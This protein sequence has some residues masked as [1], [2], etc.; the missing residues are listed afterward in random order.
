MN[1]KTVLF[2]VI[3]AL[4]VAIVVLI[5]VV[6]GGG[7]GS[8]SSGGTSASDTG[9][10]GGDTAASN[11][12]LR[13][14][15]ADP[16]TLDP[17]L[18][19]D[20]DSATYIVEIFSGLVTI[21]KDLKIAPDLAESWDIS[22]DGTVYTFHLRSNAQFQDG[23]P[24]S[25]DDVKYSLERTANPKTTS[26]VADAYLGD[27]VGARDMIRGRAQSI[28]GIKVI[29]SKTV[30]ITVDGPKPYFL[31]KLTYTAA[32]VVDKNQVESNP[33]NWTRK[34]N[35]TGPYKLQE[36]RLNERIILQANDHYHLGAPSVK[37]VLYNLAGGSSLTQYQNG[38]VDISGIS[39]N[40][41]DRVLNKSD[42]LSKE[43][44]TAPSL[45]I[46]YIG[47]DNKQKPFDD[48]KVRQAF[49]LAIDRDQI[50]HVILKDMLP[51]ANSIMQPGLPGYSPTAK[52]PSF[53]PAQAKQL[54]SQSKYGSAQGL[55][56]ITLS[57]VGAG[58]TS[59]PVAEAI[60]QMWKQN[61][62]VDVSIT[63]SEAAAFFDDLDQGKL[64]MFD[65][66]WVMDYPDPE[67]IIDL[68][69]YS[70]SRQNSSHYN[71]PDFDNL[72]LQARTEQDVTKRLQLYQQAEQMLLN[73]LPWIPMFFDKAHVVVKPYVK[74]Y[75]P[76]AMVIEHLRGLS[77]QK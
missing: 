53:D 43:Y 64:Q 9:K 61:L 62:G 41:I 4:V 68:L 19:S 75:T 46:S 63:Q 76:A 16:L 30:Q 7:G 56:P 14:I 54:L 21:D 50:G 42:P 10:Q 6:M 12:D 44:Q 71:N 51:V 8:S 26:T 34:P 59:G 55:G 24:V 23:R 47:F 73:D 67:D 15:G 60:V 22:P 5:F 37:R 66:G 77:I 13:L 18:A 72:V 20:A 58:A 74:G 1:N 31:A 39:V 70:Q 65:S 29:D 28:S 25:A 69:F 27:I 17:A 57:E 40:D 35:G 2:G 32:F 11:A 36:W 33:R 48:P 3:A 45:S 52:G 49:A 38:D